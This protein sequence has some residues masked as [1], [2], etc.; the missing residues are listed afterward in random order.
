M[1]VRVMYPSHLLYL[2][3]IDELLDILAKS[4]RNLRGLAVGSLE[5]VLPAMGQ[6]LSEN[7]AWADWQI[8]SWM[9]DPEM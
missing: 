8:R 5:T 2:V 9:V 4:L 6:I 1:A 3:E 7:P